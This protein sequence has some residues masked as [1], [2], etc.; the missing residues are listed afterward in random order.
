[1]RFLFIDRIS[2]FELSRRAVGTKFLSNMDEYLPEHYALKPV[3]PPTLILEGMAQLAGWLHVASCEFRVE[4]V[5]GLVQGAR[6]FRPV[7]PGDNLTIEV[8]LVG[9]HRDGAE[10][11][12]KAR[13]GEEVVAEVDRL[14][15]ISGRTD[16]ED[17]P[18]RGRRLLRYLAGDLPALKEP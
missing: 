14:M 10:L 2:E 16:R 6:F 1:M 3:A 13:V 8:E 12:G 5:L 11:K 7:G 4:T 17:Y 15:F 9:A 18:E